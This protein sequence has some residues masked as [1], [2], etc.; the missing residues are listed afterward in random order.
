MEENTFTICIVPLSPSLSR[1][2][3]FFKLVIFVQSHVVGAEFDNS[4]NYSQ[5]PGNKE[6]L[7]KEPLDKECLHREPISGLLRNLAQ[8]G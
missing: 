7:N 8:N 5:N 3:K 4:T 1:S 6:S 2:R